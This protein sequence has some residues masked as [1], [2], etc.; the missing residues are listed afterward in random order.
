MCASGG[1]SIEGISRGSQ[2]SLFYTPRR[3]KNISGSEATFLVKCDEERDHIICG[4]VFSVS[5]SEG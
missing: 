4:K 1:D 5:A 2:L 3:N